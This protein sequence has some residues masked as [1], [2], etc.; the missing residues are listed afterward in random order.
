LNLGQLLG[1]ISVQ[2]LTTADALLAGSALQ[3]LLGRQIGWALER[4]RLPADYGVVEEHVR[5]GVY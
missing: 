1:E 3:E 4:R 2:A 5:R